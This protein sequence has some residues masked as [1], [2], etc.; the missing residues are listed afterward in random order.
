MLSSFK[1]W[2]YVKAPV[3]HI[4]YEQIQKQTKT[5]FNENPQLFDIYIWVV[6]GMWKTSNIY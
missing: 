5:V 2:K 6:W 4:N 3:K 1:V